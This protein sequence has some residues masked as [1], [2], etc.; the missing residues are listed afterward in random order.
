M[1][2]E[3]RISFW[4]QKAPKPAERK[5]GALLCGAGESPLDFRRSKYMAS[6]PTSLLD[7]SLA[8]V[9]ESATRTLQPVTRITLV[10]KAHGGNQDFGLWCDAQV[11]LNETLSGCLLLL[12]TGWV[13]MVEGPNALI[14]SFL[15]S[16]LAQ[17]A[18]GGLLTAAK[19]VHVQ[20]DV[21]SRAFP[22][23]CSKE[24]SVQ[25]GNYT[26][27]GDVSAMAAMLADT[28]IGASR[29]AARQGTTPPYNSPTI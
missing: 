15:K 27:A 12:P 22:S 4:W 11:K 16:L 9:E 7:A 17:G 19:I 20:E 29:T 5:A 26:E 6:G 2:V 28:A 3:W 10:G 8:R 21:A 24:L 25:R 23:W 14:V 13:Q 1:R 18:P